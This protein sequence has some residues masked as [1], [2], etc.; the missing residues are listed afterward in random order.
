[1]EDRRLR[2]FFVDELDCVPRVTPAHVGGTIEAGVVTL[3]GHVISYAEKLAA[4]EITLN[5]RGARAVVDDNQ[6]PVGTS[7]DP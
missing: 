5:V 6:H 4:A 2:R 7:I 1:M 3:T